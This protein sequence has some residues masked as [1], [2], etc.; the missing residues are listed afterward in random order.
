MNRNRLLPT[1]TVFLLCLG[2]NADARAAPVAKIAQI[3]GKVLVNTGKDYLQAQPG[4][5][6]NPGDRILT[7]ANSSAR[8][9]YPDN[10]AVQM[11]ANSLV[12]MGEPDLC[13]KAG[14]RIRP[15]KP[16][17]SQSSSAT[18]A[19]TATTATP[20]TTATTA[21]TATAA[22]AGTAGT[23]T[24]FGIPAAA[25]GI[26]TVVGGTGAAIAI[27]SGSNGGGNNNGGNQPISPQ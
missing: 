14:K 2:V 15:R 26:G 10:C 20:T 1:I 19:N 9:V 22:T 11:S 24:V 18:S 21:T 6:L 17:I 3:E 4:M 13:S 8:V 5:E 25:I 7:L 16:P 12:T 27:D 23:A